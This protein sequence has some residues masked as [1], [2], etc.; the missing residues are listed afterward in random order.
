VTSSNGREALSSNCI[1][2]DFG[3]STWESAFS[4]NGIQCCPLIGRVKLDETFTVAKIV[5][6]AHGNSVLHDTLREGCVWRNYE[7]GI[8]FK[9]VD[10]IYLLNKNGEPKPKDKKPKEI[11]AVEV[12]PETV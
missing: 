1:I 8:S 2:E 3:G 11:P 6:M 7:K 12:K 5:E 4:I 10:P 9:A